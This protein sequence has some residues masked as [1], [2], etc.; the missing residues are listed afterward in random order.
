[1][2]DVLPGSGSALIARKL[3]E[4]RVGHCQQAFTWET[5]TRLPLCTTHSSMHLGDCEGTE[6]TRSL[7]LW[8]L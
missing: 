6:Q 1:M 3:Q 8:S 4:L 2:W 5:F 7:F